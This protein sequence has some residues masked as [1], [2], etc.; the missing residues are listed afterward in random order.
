MKF[1][2]VLF[3]LDGTLLDTLAD[4]ADAANLVLK[5]YGYREHA[6]DVYKQLVGEGVRVLFER[7]LPS[8]KR[9]PPVIEQCAEDFREAYSR[10]WNIQTRPYD[11]VQDLLDALVARG[12][13]MAVLSNKPDGFTKRCV[14]QYFPNSPLYPVLGQRDDVPRKPDPAGALEIAERL[15]IPADQFVY[16]GDTAVDMQTAAAAGMY[17]VGALWGFRSREEIVD[18]G[19]RK[20]IE[21]PEELLPIVACESVA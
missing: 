10:L 11:G 20:L 6:I 3:D 8:E 13:K 7:A 17:P 5:A 19:A 12:V 15:S 1:C 18:G 9:T 14:A 16:L 4:I 21:R 2:A